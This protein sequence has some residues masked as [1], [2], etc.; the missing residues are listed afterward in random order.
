M[1]KTSLLSFTIP[2]LLSVSTALAAPPAATPR[3][4]VG[5]PAAKPP[6]KKPVDVNRTPEPPKG[7]S[8]M[9]SGFVMTPIEVSLKCDETW[10]K[11][12]SD[13]PLRAKNCTGEFQSIYRLE[14]FENGRRSLEL[15]FDPAPVVGNGT[16][17]KEAIPWTTPGEL[18]AVVYFR[19]PGATGEQSVRG[20]IKIAN[21]GLSAAKEACEKCSGVWGRYGVNRYQGCNCKT[22]D[23]GK[24]CNDGDDCQGLCLFRRYDDQARE[25]GVCSEQQ[26]MT[27]CVP[28]VMKGQSQLKPRIPPPKKLP[29][30]LD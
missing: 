3:P 28:V 14:M 17:W 7:C 22:T 21:K 25:E 20:S 26:R 9:E 5:R 15:E 24:V 27:G 30:C 8:P 18:E 11:C 6:V 19:P 4:P 10:D 29:T 2:V 12:E 13:I 16:T 23:A 1:D